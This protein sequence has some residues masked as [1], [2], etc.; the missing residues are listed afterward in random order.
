MIS[1]YTDTELLGDIDMY[2]DGTVGSAAKS[3]IMELL[4]TWRLINGLDLPNAID[5]ALETANV[6]LTWVHHLQKLD[7]EVPD[8]DIP[9]AFMGSVDEEEPDPEGDL[10][11]AWVDGYP[12]EH[13]SGY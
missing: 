7:G 2:L 6:I 13:T 8:N 4:T 12:I 5:D 10:F 3:A 1:N 11:Q 9:F